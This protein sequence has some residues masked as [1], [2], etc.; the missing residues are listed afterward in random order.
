VLHQIA[1]IDQIASRQAHLVE[2]R[3]RVGQGSIRGLPKLT[4]D[5]LSDTP[6][7][8][9]ATARVVPLEF[10]NL[11]A[12]LSVEAL[13]RSSIALQLSSSRRELELVSPTDVQAYVDLSQA[14]PGTRACQARTMVPAG[15]EVT[16]TTRP[17]R[18]NSASGPRPIRIPPLGSLRPGGRCLVRD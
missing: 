2:C 5:S 16:N 10:H 6:P 9:P 4:E 11:P 7:A 14:K 18:S 12:G 8:T 17:S 3:D 1:Q 13:R 15:I